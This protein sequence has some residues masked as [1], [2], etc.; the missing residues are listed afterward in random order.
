[1]TLRYT[2]TCLFGLEG[3][4]GEEITA[5]GYKRVDNM[6]GR[7]T[8]EGDR[9]ASAVC[10]IGLRFAERLYLNLGEFEA[11]SFDSLFDLL[12]CSKRS[13]HLLHC[14]A[15]LADPGKDMRK[16]ICYFSK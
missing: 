7:I 3:L 5:L 11:K 13:L 14:L 9:E 12:F 4:L 16:L 6:D 10:N 15:A 1:M 2:A 8:F